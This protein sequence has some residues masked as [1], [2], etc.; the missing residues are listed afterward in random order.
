M[1]SRHMGLSRL[2]QILEEAGTYL[3]KFAKRNYLS[4]LIRGVSDSDE[5]KRMGESLYLN[6]VVAS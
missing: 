3:E 5:V 4:R 1:L 6:A 2:K